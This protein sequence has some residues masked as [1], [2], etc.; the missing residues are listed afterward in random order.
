MEKVRIV[1]IAI[2]VFLLTGCVTNRQNPEKTAT[3]VIVIDEENGLL[4]SESVYTNSQTLESRWNPEK[5]SM[6]IFDRPCPN[7]NLLLTKSSR[8]VNPEV[9]LLISN[10]T[11]EKLQQAFEKKC[12]GKSLRQE[13]FP[14]PHWILTLTDDNGDQ[15][16]ESSTYEMPLDF[17]FEVCD[18]YRKCAETDARKGNQ[19]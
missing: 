6:I 4:G 15:L 16:F 9:R 12:R 7:W 18:Q 1:I 8:A 17:Y 3:S 19:P 14:A 2:I 11:Y 13:G 10:K 5:G